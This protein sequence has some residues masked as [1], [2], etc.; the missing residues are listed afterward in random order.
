MKKWTAKHYRLAFLLGVLI[1]IL[2]AIALVWVFKV[3]I[4][5]AILF[6]LGLSFAW[7][8]VLGTI[9]RKNASSLPPPPKS[10]PPQS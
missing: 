6:A 1:I 3:W 4:A 8:C 7:L 5:L 9:I 10:P 2:M